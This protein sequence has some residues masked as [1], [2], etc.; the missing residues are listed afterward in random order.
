[1]TIRETG[2]TRDVRKN[3]LAGWRVRLSKN[4]KQVANKFFTDTVNGG[5]ECSLAHARSYRDLA[6]S[7][8]SIKVEKTVN[9]NLLATRTKFGLTQPQAAKLLNVCTLTYSRWERDYKSTRRNI[10]GL[11][12]FLASQ[13]T[14]L[15]MLPA[16]EFSNVRKQ[17]GLSRMEMSLLLCVSY[18][19]LSR[20]E[21][22]KCKPETW[23]YTFISAIH[24]GWCAYTQSNSPTIH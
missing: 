6:A 17:L 20:W 15:S 13:K 7:Q 11:L 9:Q 16:S 1:M 23:A 22:S 2:L 12:E 10:Q 4:G 14:T 8:F 3:G 24:A 5:E 18:E 21:N 19:T